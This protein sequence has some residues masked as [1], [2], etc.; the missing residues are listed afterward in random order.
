MLWPPSLALL[1]RLG[2]STLEEW[3]SRMASLAGIGGIVKTDDPSDGTSNVVFP[4]PVDLCAWLPTSALKD[5]VK[6]K[7]TR[8]SSSP[9]IRRRDFVT[10]LAPGGPDTFPGTGFPSRVVF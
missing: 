3:D 9:D 4:P 8:P 1:C 6:T 10:T 5:E 2:Y 7:G